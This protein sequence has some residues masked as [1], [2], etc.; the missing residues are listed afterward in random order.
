MDVNFES[1]LYF[2][3]ST[4]HLKAYQFLM[5]ARKTGFCNKCQAVIRLPYHWN[6]EHSL[7]LA[8]YGTEKPSTKP[9]V[10]PYMWITG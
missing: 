9:S 8:D 3:I 2:I 7:V 5:G 1:K 10:G 4:G 6:L